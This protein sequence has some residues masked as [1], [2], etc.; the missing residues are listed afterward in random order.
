MKYIDHIFRVAVVILAIAM[1]YMWLDTHID[2]EKIEPVAPV[3]DAPLPPPDISPHKDI[4]A[5]HAVEAG[6]RLSRISRLI[7]RDEGN[8]N[9]L[10][11]DGKD[12][13]KIGVGRSL[14]TNGLSIQELYAIVPEIDHEYVFSNT[15]VRHARVYI[16]K[17]AVA[18]LIFVDPL[19][20]HDIDL[21][22][23]D[24]LKNV[25]ADA[26]NVF[27][28]QWNNISEPRREAIIDTIFNLGLTHFK[29]FH[30]FIGAVK[31]Q[32]WNKAADELLLSQAARKHILRYHRNS[33]VVRSGDAKYFEL[34]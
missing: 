20:K 9:K 15:E 1:I 30:N 26:I 29:G 22:L 16:D 24:D 7:I 31:N 28:E 32:D 6:T 13:V 23:T 33:A 34:K 3:L 12:I 5:R 18:N 11:L 27:G 19:T 4:V 25:T 17:L 21:L 14:Q 8:K 10:Y 2:V